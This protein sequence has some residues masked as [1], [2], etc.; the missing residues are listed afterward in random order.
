MISLKIQI[1]TI[2]FSFLYGIFF[3]LLIDFNYKFIHSKNKITKYF[4]TIL[5]ILLGVIIYFIGIM[6]ISYGIFHVYSI[7][8]I[9][10]GYILIS[11]IQGSIAK[12]KIK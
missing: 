3:S 12:K 10:S 7:L 11:F 9:L 8:C 6:K 4:S 2:I 1:Y 5:I